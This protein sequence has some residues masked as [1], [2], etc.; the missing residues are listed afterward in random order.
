MPFLKKIEIEERKDKI[1]SIT[2]EIADLQSK[3]DTCAWTPNKVFMRLGR[4]R[5]V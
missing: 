1:L 3:H 4:S 5:Q 2:R